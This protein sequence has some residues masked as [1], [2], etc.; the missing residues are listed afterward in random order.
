LERTVLQEVNELKKEA[1]RRP[2]T[3]I[4]FLVPSKDMGPLD[5]S[6]WLCQHFLLFFG[7]FPAKWNQGEIESLGLPTRIAFLAR[8]NMPGIPQQKFFLTI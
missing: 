6:F 7:K 3:T 2:L 1:E 8:K 5:K 4:I